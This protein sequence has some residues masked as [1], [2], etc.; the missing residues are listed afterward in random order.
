MLSEVI[1][2]IFAGLGLFFIGVKIIG[3]NLRGMTGKGFRD[4]IS[5]VTKRG[6]VSSIMGV[7]SGAIT[8][9]TTAITFIMTS[10]ISA[11]LITTR[12]AMPIVLWSNVGNCLLVFL[13]VINFHVMVLYVIG[14][15]GF[16][17][18]L[19]LDRSKQ[20][21]PLVGLLLGIVL[22]FYGLDLMKSGAA[23]LKN[24]NAVKEFILF[25]DQNYLLGLVAAG[26]LS[27]VAQSAATVSAI[28]IA[29]ANTGILNL[30][31]ALILIYG[32]N[33]GPAVSTWLM[34]QKLDGPAKQLAIF[35]VIFK[36]TGLTVMMVL[37]L[38]EFELGIPLVGSLLSTV[39]EQLHYQLA[40]AYLSFQVIGALSMTVLG[41]PISGWLIKKY[42]ERAEDLLGKPKYIFDEALSDPASALLLVEK[43]ELRVLS[44]YPM[45]F[46]TVRDGANMV[47]P[48]HIL[49][50]GSSSLIMYI[51]EY[52]QAMLGEHI[53]RGLIERVLT[54]QKRIEL[55]ANM[56][57]CIFE[58]VRIPFHEK[59]SEEMRI[60]H[61]NIIESMHTLLLS[62][63]DLMGKYDREDKDLI[64]Q[65][66]EDRG[67]LMKRIHQQIRKTHPDLGFEE[68]QVF[69]LLASRF[70]R[71]VWMVRYMSRLAD[72]SMLS[73]S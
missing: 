14:V 54:S 22:L 2:F 64:F 7:M 18:Y 48:P 36:F 62:L 50:I 68:Q 30:E 52:L 58:V 4:L 67:D 21:K 39:T 17:H 47:Y 55:L 41:N 32:S 53:H 71:F 3:T 40:L 19:N 16:L 6:W 49:H 57:E 8:Q 73:S 25:T 59:F 56:E 34:A 31:G 20:F 35:Q 44:R 42:P 26:I 13:A 69:E 37:F 43:E 61:G 15:V 46:D 1:G 51:E 38:L 63:I 29:L 11:G 45:Y 10:M 70:E 28:T 23:P 66:T 5:Q 72:E 24:Y 27:F 60:C 12:R 9:S 65:L 33:L